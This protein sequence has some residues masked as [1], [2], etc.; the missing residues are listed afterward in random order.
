ML[1]CTNSRSAKTVNNKFMRRKKI[2]F[3]CSILSLLVLLFKKMLN[4][5]EFVI[6]LFVSFKITIIILAS[7]ELMRK[8]KRNQGKKN[9]RGENNRNKV[10]KHKI[11]YSV[12]CFKSDN[13]MG[14]KKSNAI[15]IMR[16]VRVYVMHRIKCI[17][18][19]NSVQQSS[20][21]SVSR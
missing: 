21:K 4:W 16:V 7:E 8:A 3:F 2:L 11:V 6:N 19:S 13:K 14:Y 18:C 20:Q 10:I 1:T 5:S 15:E 17:K 9:W 12:K